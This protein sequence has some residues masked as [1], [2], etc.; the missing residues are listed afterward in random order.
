ME[1]LKELAAEFG[2]VLSQEQIAQFEEYYERLVEKNKVMNLTAITE[3]EEVLVK[4][5]LDSLSICRVVDFGQG[6]EQENRIRMAK[7][8]RILDLGTGAGFPGLPLK[9]AFPDMEIVLAD[10]LNKRILFLKEVISALG[11]SGISAVHGRAEELARMDIYREKFSL[12]VSR[13]V[14]NL[15]VLAEYCLPFVEVGGYF[16]SYKAANSDE[17]I[18]QAKKAVSVLGGKIVENQSFLL[19]Q[20]DIGRNLIVI[21][22]IKATGKKYPRNAGKPSK[23]P[24]H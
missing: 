24:I 17:E 3:K 8:S 20:S 2:A 12:V 19:P 22:K 6:E 14:A 15:A 1:K 10:S 13:A 21:K 11:L 9:I 23:E 18:G 5:F 4:H 7:G 16:I